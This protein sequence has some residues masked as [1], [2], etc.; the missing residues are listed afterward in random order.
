MPNVT[1][2][3]WD[4]D[5]TIVRFESQLSVIFKLDSTKGIMP[6]N[7]WHFYEIVTVTLI[8]KKNCN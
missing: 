7:E 8:I 2:V 6:R 4:T 5:C 1:I 3:P